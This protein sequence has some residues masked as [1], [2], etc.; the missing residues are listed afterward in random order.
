MEYV[1]LS[2]KNQLL[3]L[4]LVAFSSRIVSTAAI[5]TMP[6]LSTYV[7]IDALVNVISLSVP[8]GADVSTSLFVLNK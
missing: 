5:F 2:E 3:L 7:A 6:Y 1:R 4:L 8:V